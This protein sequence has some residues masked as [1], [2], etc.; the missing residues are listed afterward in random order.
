ML[1]PL[2]IV[3]IR[4]QRRSSPEEQFMGNTEELQLQNTSAT[5]SL[6]G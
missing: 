1:R 5:Q 4:K 3:H 2:T 6:N